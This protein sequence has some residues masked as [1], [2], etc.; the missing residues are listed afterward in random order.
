MCY[1]E[2]KGGGSLYLYQLGTD[3]L[4][5]L[6]SVIRTITH[7]R[8]CDSLELCQRLSHA[9]SIELIFNKNPE[10]KRARSRR[11][12]AQRDFT[13]QKQWTG[14]LGVN[15]CD[16]RST[17]KL[18]EIEA[19]RLLNLKNEYYTELKEKGVTM[20]RP[21]KRL[22]G[23]N[24]DVERSEIPANEEV[25]ENLSSLDIE[26][27]LTN[28]DEL[29]NSITIDVNGKQVHKATVVKQLFESTAASNDRLRRVRGYGKTPEIDSTLS[30][31]TN[32]DL[33]DCILLGDTVA[34]KITVKNNSSSFCLFKIKS[35][36]DKESKKFETIISGTAIGTKI[37]SCEIL[38][39]RLC[40]EKLIVVESKTMKEEIIIGGEFTIFVRLFQ[41]S[42]NLNDILLLIKQLPTYKIR[43]DYKL[44]P[45]HS[46]LTEGCVMEADS[47]LIICKICSKYIQKKKMRQHVGSHILSKDIE[48]SQNVCG[49]CGTADTCDISI[50]RGSGRGK[51]ASEIP[52]STC[53]YFEKFSLKSAAKST[54]TS[55]CTNRPIE[56]PTCKRIFWSY[57]M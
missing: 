28:G 16:L 17:W 34:A 33:N 11:L 52:Q 15:E 35:I 50:C 7:A 18:G 38:A 27:V 57:N 25:E 41:S 43:N 39:G 42:L 55:P 48:S 46:L 4:E 32:L 56:C 3:Q 10:W 21:K 24:V 49:F 37:I 5:N 2:K 47:S 36:K 44:L 45:Y 20:M 1:F 22:V 12:G 26:K 30:S 6:F 13:S 29:G 8:N 9:E 14:E 51:T 23:V 19:I 31:M 54:K 53:S 40:D